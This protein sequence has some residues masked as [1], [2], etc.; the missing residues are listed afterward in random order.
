MI[1]RFA[2]LPRT[3]KSLVILAADMLFLPVAFWFAIGLRT[4]VWHVPPGQSWWIYLLPSAI[5]GPI[6][7]KF[8][9]YRSVIRYLEERAIL[10]MLGAVTLSVILISYLVMLLASAVL[11]VGGLFIF[12]MLACGYVFG[13]RF[14]ARAVL[15]QQF[16][17]EVSRKK[18]IIYGAGSAGIQMVNALKAGKEFEP[19]AFVD[20]EPNLQGL[21]LSGLQVFSPD[22][23][24]RLRDELDARHVLLALPSASRNRRVEIVNR[25]EPL[26]LEVK[27]LPGMVDLV[28]GQVALSDVREVG[29]DELLGRDAVPPDPDLLGRC[30]RGKVVMVTGAGGSIGS[31]LCRQIVDCEPAS[32]LLYEISEFALYSIEQELRQRIVRTGQKTCLLPVLGS[33]RDGARLKLLM[34]TYAVQTIYHAAAYKH[35]PLVEFNITEGVLNNTAGT[36][37]A[38]RAAKEAG[39]ETFVLISTDKAVRPTNVM[40]ASKRMAE[41]ALQALA[42]EPHCKTRFSMVRFGNVLGSSGSVV[43]L[44]RRQIAAGGPVTV[45]HPEII[46][47]FMTIPEASQLVIQAGAMGGSGEVFVLDMGKPVKILE[48]ARRMVHLSGLS[49][50]D[51]HHPDG[52]I[53]IQF[54]GLRPGEKLYEELLIGDDV[55]GTNHPK[56]M[57]AKEDFIPAQQYEEVITLLQN[58][59]VRGDCSAIINLL[60]LHVSGFKPDSEIRDHLDCKVAGA[61]QAGRT[62]SAHVQF[63]VV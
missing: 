45:T 11:P 35:V 23:L 7:L 47:Y 43:P 38:A 9:L 31:E 2:N 41:L 40:G 14:M 56:I 24:P 29:I 27:V 48:L 33:V 12:W 50:R 44:F 20:D 34:T 61:V 30:I 52:D 58:A 19:A 39:V 8:G 57:K 42:A 63:K 54:S 60:N 49:V 1:N 21:I 37:T 5:A 62:V 25:L 32:L 53:E 26:K 55:S 10:A 16:T 4:N 28:E 17:R 6:F 22:E 51:A 59:C 13:S 46:R 36:W 15:R 18:V 3:T